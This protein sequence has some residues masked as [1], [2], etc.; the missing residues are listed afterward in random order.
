M[1]KD[2]TG[3]TLGKYQVMERLGRGGMA[4]VYRAYQP[5][6]DRY[7]AI[8][9]MHAHLADDPNFLARFQREA[10]SVG[11][12]RHPNI[13]QVIDFDAQDGEYYMVMEY[14]KGNTLKAML[15]ERGALPVEEALN[16]AIKL[17]DALAYAHRQ[18]MIHRDIKPANI[19]MTAPDNPV[20][21]DFGIAHLMDASGLTASGMAIGTP[22]YMSPEAGRGEKVDERADIYSL[23][24]VLYEM[25]T[26][27]VPYDA[28]TPYAVIL[29]HIN[30][31][32]PLLR[33]LVE[34]LPESV[35]RVV[36]KSLAKPREERFQTAADFR[37]ALQAAR[38]TLQAGMPTRSA[39]GAAATALP[40]STQEGTVL[41]QPAH[42]TR[43]NVPL[44]VGALVVLAVVIGGGL[45]LLSTRPATTPTALAASATT[46]SVAQVGPTRQAT[47]P[48]TTVPPTV[49]PTVAPTSAPT[50][51]PTTPPTVGSAALPTQLP[52]TIAPATT[53]PS[54][55][56]ASTSASQ[57]KYANLIAQATQ[58]LMDGDVS[59]ALAQLEPPL[60]SDPQSY[61]LLALHALA[62][63][64]TG[65]AESFPQALTEA[66][67]A[68]KIDPNRPE[69]YVALGWYYRQMQSQ[70]S[71]ARVAD[72][73]KSVSNFTQ[74]ITVGTKDYSAYWGRAFAN[75]DL[76]GYVGSDNGASLDDISKDLET[77]ASFSPKDRRFYYQVG[78]FYYD[79][80]VYD[81]ARLYF[82]QARALGYED[83][84]TLDGYLGVIYALQGDVPKAFKLFSDQ[85][86]KKNNH[87]PR[88]LAA[89]A[90]MAW[91]NNS[92]DLT[93]EWAELA[94]ALEPN[95]PGA[96][97]ALAMLDWDAK[98]YDEAL[99]KLDAVAKVTD[100]STYV[101]PFLQRRLDRDVD[102]DRGRILALTGKID[103]AIAAYEAAKNND[104][105][106][107][108]IWIEQAKLYQQ[109]GKIDDARQDLRTALDIAITD[110][111][112][113]TRAEVIDL[114]KQ[115]GTPMPDAT[116]SS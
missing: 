32:L 95:T 72:L 46:G 104:A 65:Q 29:K 25:I 8:K 113:K 67:A 24:I 101:W 66:Q 63:V 98:K 20:L 92:K 107:S 75:L 51:V 76:N 12:L 61:D 58:K 103:D 52:A 57:G 11:N 74:A 79:Q 108:K 82:E 2:L 15:K 23:G 31:P 34:S 116:A 94:L 54:T 86:V 40:R 26:G 49:P 27:T 110:K 22:A 102:V 70:D 21:T 9:V 45:V 64:A 7:V 91:L 5:G 93:R 62:L 112:D 44:I 77:A 14:I 41:G 19:L 16:I 17:A 100:R 10:R 88:Y 55:N 87:E 13:V 39:K 56:V 68:I 35:E 90:Y 71:D 106:W 83:N 105:N 69:A 96:T 6:M 37:D 30:D 85:I 84:D 114:L 47:A 97:Y 59:G 111:D 50:T 89:G 48:A 99:K 42:P 4:D 60:K 36:L 33:Q 80:R 109:Q 43:S 53:A 1:A 28:D 81:R 18:G 115:L 78:G 3:T 38:D 73:K